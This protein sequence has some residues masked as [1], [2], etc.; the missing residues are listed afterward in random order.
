[1]GVKMNTRQAARLAG[2]SRQCIVNWILNGSLP[3]SK[4][5]G[6]QYLLDGTDVLKRADLRKRHS[7]TIKVLAFLEGIEGRS[8]C[9]CPNCPT[10]KLFCD[11]CKTYTYGISAMSGLEAAQFIRSKLKEILSA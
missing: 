2:V 7:R 3:A 4:V 11:V 6:K 8:F 5:H 10:E 1:M 9:N